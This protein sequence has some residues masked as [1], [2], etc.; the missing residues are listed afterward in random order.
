MIKFRNDYS[1]GTHPSIL[2]KILETN[3]IQTVGYGEDE[4]CETA[5][6]KIKTHLK[7]DAAAVHFFVG[8]TATN[9]TSLSAFLRPHESILA[10][11]TAHICL[12]ETGA[13][14]ATGHS[15]IGVPN[16]AGKISPEQIELA[17]NNHLPTHMTKIRIVYISNS[18][19][20]G[21]IYTK[22]E[23]Y[24]LRDACKKHNLLL[25]LDG[26]RLGVALT[27]D[28]NDLDITDICNCVDAFYIGGTKNGALFGE[29][30]VIV[31]PS[32]QSDF[33]YFIKQKGALLAKG[34]LLGI[35][36]LA[37]FE[38]NLY[39]KLAKHA[40]DM[41]KIISHNIEKLGFKLFISTETNQIFVI[42]SL[43][44]HNQLSQHID[45]EIW[46][47]YDEQH[48]VI[49]FVTSWATTADMVDTLAGHMGELLL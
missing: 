45:Y 36:F 39:Y 8:G 9:L 12:H 35:Q 38:D 25:Y 26:A 31:N 21:S 23:L 40:N 2:N 47:P 3:L 24:S 18:T 17:I 42:L 41:A 33:K 46:E 13:I 15:I 28:K 32:L 44:Q 16:A 49:R 1:E 37:L 48:I 43:A 11:D 29:A 27:C 4:Y 14:E 20:Y 34:R 19:E 6:H 30:L 10:P 7:C 22:A 5:R